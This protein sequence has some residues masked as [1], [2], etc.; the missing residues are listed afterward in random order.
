MCRSRGGSKYISIE[1]AVCMYFGEI[2]ILVLITLVKKPYMFNVIFE[3]CIIN[4]SS[5]K[6][7]KM[8]VLILM[9]N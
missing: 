8:Y 4:R 2:R 6:V 3:N 9:V 1:N 5:V 7:V